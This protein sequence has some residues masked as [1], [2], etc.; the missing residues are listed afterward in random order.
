M[1]SIEH[2]GFLI[3]L[4]NISTFE[5]HFHTSLIEPVLLLIQK[6]YRKGNPSVVC[7]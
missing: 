5:Q 1:G 3:D 7:I 6:N 2:G 4:L